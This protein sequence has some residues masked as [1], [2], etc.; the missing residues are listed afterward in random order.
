MDFLLAAGHS[1]VLYVTS[2]PPQKKNP[3]TDMSCRGRWVHVFPCFTCTSETE[4]F[5]F[6]AKRGCITPLWWSEMMCSHY[7]RLLMRSTGHVLIIY[8]TRPGKKKLGWK[9]K[10]LITWLHSN[11]IQC[12]WEITQNWFYRVHTSMSNSSLIQPHLNSPHPDL[13]V[14][15]QQI[16]QT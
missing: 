15:L 12:I 7:L 13:Y 11:I 3:P 4:N 16:A 6:G 5:S 8:Q 2:P 14:D 9:K 1:G 10:K